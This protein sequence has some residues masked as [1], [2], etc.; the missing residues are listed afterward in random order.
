MKKYI[1]ALMTKSG[2]ETFGISQIRIVEAENEKEGTERYLIGRDISGESSVRLLGEVKDTEDPH[3]CIV[4]MRPGNFALD[5]VEE[6]RKHASFSII[7]SKGTEEIAHEEKPNKEDKDNEFVRLAKETASEAASE[8]FKE[9][10]YN[11]ESDEKIGKIL[12]PLLKESVKCIFDKMHHKSMFSWELVREVAKRGDMEYINP[13]GF[14]F[15]RFSSDENTDKDAYS[16]GSHIALKTQDVNDAYQFMIE[17]G[18]EVDPQF[19]P[20]L[21]STEP[22]DFYCVALINRNRKRSHWAYVGIRDEDYEMAKKMAIFPPDSAEENLD[23]FIKMVYQRYMIQ[24]YSFNIL[25][26]KEISI[27]KIDGSVKIYTT[28]K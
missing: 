13:V 17:I 24:N 3:V 8:L 2:E 9:K 19:Y 10:S 21:H 4:E 28:G 6:R 14:M 5:V 1:F 20:I 22:S 12:G 15:G 11:K 16:T 25:A 27:K 26:G 7:N 18:F 23:K